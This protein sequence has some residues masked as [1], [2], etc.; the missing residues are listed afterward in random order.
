MKVVILAGGLGTRISEET[1]FKPKP[2]VLIGDKPILWHIMKIYSSYGFNEFVICLGY[3]GFAVK[4]YFAN[5]LMQESDVEIN[6]STGN[7]SYLKNNSENWKVTLVNTGEKTMTGGRIKRIKPY[8]GNERFFLTYGDGVGDIN[9]KELLDFHLKQGKL[10]TLTSTKPF[11]RFGVIETNPQ[12]LITSFKEKNAEDT[13]WINGGFFVCE[14]QVID[15]IQDDTTVWEK[16]PLEKLTQMG[17][18]SAF[19]HNGFWRAMDSLND[20]NV[21]EEYWS[22]A[23]P[24]W[25]VWQ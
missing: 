19:K 25:K 4:E 11:G 10:A 23:N 18:L 12:G 13:S 3:K 1:L 6:T 17:E 24:P 21:L 20:K 2:M 8:I 16:D 14:P 22:S 15:Y 5:Y 7:I 9:I